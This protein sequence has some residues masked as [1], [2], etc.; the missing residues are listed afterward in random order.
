MFNS[1]VFQFCAA[2]TTHTILNIN[3]LISYLFVT[4][5]QNVFY[6]ITQINCISVNTGFYFDVTASSDP[7]T[8]TLPIVYCY[9]CSSSNQMGD[10]VNVR[11]SQYV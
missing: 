2:S 1:L 8:A 10:I 11:S 4:K 6:K 7:F 3:R 5:L 9:V